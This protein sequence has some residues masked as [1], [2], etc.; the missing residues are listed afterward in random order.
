MYSTVGGV[1]YF[2]VSTVLYCTLYSYLPGSRDYSTKR[3]TVILLVVPAWKY[4]VSSVKKLR[5]E[6][7]V[8]GHVNQHFVLW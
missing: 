2:L 3:I 4:D 7:E 8:N 6:T 5:I 1:Q